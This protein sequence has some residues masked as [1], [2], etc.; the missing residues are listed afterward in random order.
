VRH[1]VPD[2]T[3]ARELLGFQATVGVEDGLARTIAWHKQ[4]RG[5][6]AAEA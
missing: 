3:K 2:T 6:H 4:Q 1:R 5:V